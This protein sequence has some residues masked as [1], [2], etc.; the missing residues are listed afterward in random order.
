LKD[1]INEL[2]SSSKS[3]NTR[4]LYREINEF[5]KSYQP[6]T[7]LLTDERDDLLADYY[8]ILNRWKNYFC[9]LL[10]IDGAGGVRQTEM[11]IAEPFVSPVH[12][13]LGLLLG[14]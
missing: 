14:N 7:N 5:K 4:D 8:K 11:H 3:K 9:Q 12:L 2:E 1:K 13:R 6:M 10:N